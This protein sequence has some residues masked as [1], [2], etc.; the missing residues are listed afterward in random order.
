MAENYPFTNGKLPGPEISTAAEKKADY[1]TPATN[2]T[3]TTNGKSKS[4]S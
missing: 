1:E 3:G 4:L 2:V